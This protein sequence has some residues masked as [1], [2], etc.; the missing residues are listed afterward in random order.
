LVI[1][2]TCHIFHAGATAIDLYI[3]DV[4]DCGAAGVA[5]TIVRELLQTVVNRSKIGVL[6]TMTIF[7]AISQQ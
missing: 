5:R 4:N 6:G 2:P 3:I 1:T 7:V